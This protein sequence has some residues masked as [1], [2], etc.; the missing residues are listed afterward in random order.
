MAS[1]CE[2]FLEDSNSYY[3]DV[4]MTENTCK[5]LEHTAIV[6]ILSEVLL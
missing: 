3:F 1:V 2:G 4:H 6:F 5:G